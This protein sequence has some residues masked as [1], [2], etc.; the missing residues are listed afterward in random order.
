MTIIDLNLTTSELQALEQLK[1]SGDK[2]NTSWEACIPQFGCDVH[3]KDL[4]TNSLYEFLDSI[5]HEASPELI[6]QIGALLTNIINKITGSISELNH[7]HGSLLLETFM[8]TDS[9]VAWHT[10]D[11]CRDDISDN[12]GPS[13]IFIATL[14]GE[15]TLHYTGTYDYEPNI[16]LPLHNNNI[17]K[18]LFVDHKMPYSTPLG[19][20][21]IH[22]SRHSN[23]AMHSAPNMT[24]PR[25]LLKLVMQSDKCDFD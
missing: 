17:P 22:I 6:N 15:H 18:T 8:P 4:P 16:C 23:G 5:A 21:S 19:F 3:S 2:N 20:A 14:K 10:D 1:M 24:K 9:L 25:L 13:F 7:Y 11:F 12:L